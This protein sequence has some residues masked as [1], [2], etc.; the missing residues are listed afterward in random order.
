MLL[1][2]GRL[3]PNFYTNTVMLMCRFGELEWAEKFI[4]Q[5]R[6]L[7]YGESRG[8][9]LAFTYNLAVLR[10]YQE[11]YQET[12]GLLFNEIGRFEDPLYS[13]GARTYLCRALWEQGDWE[14]LIAALHAF[15]QF[16]SRNTQLGKAEKAN[17][18]KFIQYLEKMAR[19]KSGN[20][21]QIREKLRKVRAQLEA[22]GNRQLFAWVARAM[23]RSLQ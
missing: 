8:E 9:E 14:W 3:S 18:L 20:P 7:I 6:A 10:F 13:V 5:F 15:R 2:N 23:D 1:D 11:K 22:E 19:I 21:Q 4:F 12:I 17:N 16:L